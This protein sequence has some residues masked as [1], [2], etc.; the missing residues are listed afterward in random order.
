[1][2]YF[3][4][5]SNLMRLV[6]C[7]MF[8][9]VFATVSPVSAHDASSRVIIDTD[10]AL[11]DLRAIA[12][13]LLDDH[14]DVVAVVT[15]DGACSPVT[16][17]ANVRRALEF[18][19]HGDIPVGAGRVLGMSAPP[20]RPMSEAMG[21]ADIPAATGDEG[22][23]TAVET[24]LRVLERE[25]TPAIYVCLGPMTNLAGALEADPAIGE[26]IVAVYYYGT[27][28]GSEEV[29]WNTG[30]DPGAAGAV[31]ASG[32]PLYY[33]SLPDS[34]LL[35]FDETFFGEI[36]GFDSRGAEFLRRLHT[37]ERVRELLL[38]GHFVAW[39]ET[40]ALCLAEPMIAEFEPDRRN[41]KIFHLLSFDLPGARNIYLQAVKYGGGGAASLRNA[42]VFGEFPVDPA[43]MRSDIALMAAEIIKRHG[44]EE[45]K[46]AVITNELHRHLGIYSILGVKMGIRA[47]EILNATL[48]DLEVISHASLRPP[49]SCMNDG[50]QAST[51]ASLGRGT[52][53]IDP[54][55]MAAEAV[56]VKGGTRLRMTVRD[57]VVAGI[58][59]KIR[60]AIAEYGDLT[61][62]YFEEVRRQSLA[63][64]LEM[65]RG[66]IFVETME[67]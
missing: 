55:C 6:V 50:L 9:A 7:A 5:I 11:D 63:C 22:F 53:S 44:L 19:G 58:R 1:M 43:L 57:D 52:I 31:A 21:W 33:C 61:P 62:E 48:D 67:N 18:L 47:R 46:A 38:R 3:R 10:A 29:S 66:K 65:D 17:A 12:L 26:R 4:K 28:P 60:R 20:W 40:V 59:E 54:S 49:L 39:D 32:I 30:R 41:T 37:G 13:I 14:F 36:S 2:G 51:G 45:W 25:K 15:S 23:E 34:S 56:F 27:G 42:V 64:W 35:R 24:T 16:G 8:V